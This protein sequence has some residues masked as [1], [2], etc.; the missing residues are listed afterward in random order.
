M[1][2]SSAPR[3]SSVRPSAKSSCGLRRRAKEPEVRLADHPSIARRL[4]ANKLQANHTPSRDAMVYGARLAV[5][6][7]STLS[8]VLSTAVAE[9]K[10]GYARQ[11]MTRSRAAIARFK[12]ANAGEN[13]AE[14][15]EART[16]LERCHAEVKRFLAAKKAVKSEKLET[17]I[18]KITPSA[19]RQPLGNSTRSSAADQTWRAVLISKP[20]SSGSFSTTPRISRINSASSGP[21]PSK[22]VWRSV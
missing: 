19:G 12:Y 13:P 17:T 18:R 7:N 2:T 1:S 5:R 16:A 10:H 9:R 15:A 14:P 22:L 21:S 6:A 8:V 11:L 3:G 4:V 20:A